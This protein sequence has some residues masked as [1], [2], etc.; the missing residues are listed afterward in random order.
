MNVFRIAG[1]AAVAVVALIEP[2]FAGIGPTP[3]PVAGVGLASV[4]IVG[5]A[6]WLGR[7]LLGRNK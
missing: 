1:L 6:Y 2:V 4:A 5:G 7:R 3:G